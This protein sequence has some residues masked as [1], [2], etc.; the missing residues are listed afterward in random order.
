M[1]TLQIKAMT[2]AVDIRSGAFKGTREFLVFGGEQLLPQTPLES[3]P[4][5]AGDAAQSAEIL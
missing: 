3:S 2:Q 1:I 4:S 5:A